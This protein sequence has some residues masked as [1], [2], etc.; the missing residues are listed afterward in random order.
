MLY[1]LLC[2]S[3]S[4]FYFSN[5][6]DWEERESWFRCFVCLPGAS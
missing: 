4:P 6:L 2:V 3:L 5:R 1:V